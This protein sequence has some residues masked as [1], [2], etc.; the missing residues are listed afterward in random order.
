LTST[1]VC[2]SEGL[3]AKQS[4]GFDQ[5]LAKAH[6]QLAEL[7]ARLARGKTGKA[8]EKVEAETAQILAPRWV[9]RGTHWFVSGSL[10]ST[11]TQWSSN[12]SAY[13]VGRRPI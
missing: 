1:V 11:R 10:G 9:S 13:A 2:H 6:R 7:K 8:K 3:G 4:R 5:T 12:F